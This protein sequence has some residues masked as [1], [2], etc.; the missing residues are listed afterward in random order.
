MLK[1]PIIEWANEVTRHALKEVQITNKN[2]F[3]SILL[4]DY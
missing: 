4:S 2:N 3:K 1:N